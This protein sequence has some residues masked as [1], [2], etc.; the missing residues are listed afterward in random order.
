MKL[1]NS[2]VAWGMS[3]SKYV[4]EAAKNCANHVNDNFP[5]KYNLPACTEN[6]FV[7][8]Y[9]SVMHTSKALDPDEAYYFNPLLALCSGC[10]KLVGL[11]L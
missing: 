6:P 3:P 10:L 4:R 9:E 5:G 1:R 7:M 8:G 2:V 11:I